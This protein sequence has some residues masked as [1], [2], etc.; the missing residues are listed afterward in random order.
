MAVPLEYI[1]LIYTIILAMILVVVV[2]KEMIRQLAVYAI[3]FG[4]LTNI[5][6]VIIA[7]Q[8]LDL[9]G[10]LNFMPFGVAGIPFFPPIAWTVYFIMF[11]Y[12][13]P[14]QK[15]WNYVFTLTASLYAVFF[16]NVLVN[17]ELFYSNYGR[18]IV[19]LLLYGS[20]HFTVMLVYQRFFLHKS[21][22]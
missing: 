9:G 19:P 13:L 16:A 7:T 3:I 8:L 17:I 18:F 4:A 20:W 6:L 2:P 22:Y 5:I 14:E 12:F 1:Y 11:M 15:P 21:V 10:H